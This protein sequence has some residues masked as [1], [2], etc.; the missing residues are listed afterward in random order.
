ML[1][2]R[3]IFTGATLVLAMSA[4]SLF[5]QTQQTDQMSQQSQEKIEVSDAELGKFAKAFKQVQ[6]MGQQEQVKMAKTVKDE[7]LDVQRFNEI[8]KASLDPNKESDATPEEEKKHK[9]I[10]AKLDTMQQDFEGNMKK[11]VENQD[12]EIDRFQQISMALRT[13]KDLQQRLQQMLQ[14]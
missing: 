8:H 5:A 6:V 1:H 14:S 3:K 11:I 10:L 13:D 7:G 9:A 12:M 4:S 2:I